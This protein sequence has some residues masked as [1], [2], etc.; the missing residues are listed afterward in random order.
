[1]QFR[2]AKVQAQE[3]A[4][5]LGVHLQSVTSSLNGQVHPLDVVVAEHALAVSVELTAA[6]TKIS[7]LAGSVVV[8]FVTVELEVMFE[9]AGEAVVNSSPLEAGIAVAEISPVALVE[10]ELVEMIT[11]AVEEE[12]GSAWT[13][14]MLVVGGV[15]P[16]VAL[17]GGKLV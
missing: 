10:G 13:E 12:V 9:A 8:V 2:S 16:S 17:V 15:E 5:S 6:G 1:M 11:T 3:L 4:E 7:V 14:V